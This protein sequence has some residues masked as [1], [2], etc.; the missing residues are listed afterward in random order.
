MMDQDVEMTSDE[1]FEA[2]PLAQAM[3]VTPRHTGRQE[4][5]AALCNRLSDPNGTA[6][7][8]A[9]HRA[10]LRQQKDRNAWVRNPPVNATPRSATRA[11]RVPRKPVRSNFD[12]TSASEGSLH[13]PVC[14]RGGNKAEV[15]NDSEVDFQV[16]VHGDADPQSPERS[17]TA[18]KQAVSAFWRILGLDKG[19]P[20][21]ALSANEFDVMIDR[22][23]KMEEDNNKLI[24]NNSILETQIQQIQNTSFRAISKSSWTLLDDK[25]IDTIL[26]EIHLDL[27]EWCDYNCVEDIGSLLKL[28]QEMLDDV[29]YEIRNVAYAPM[30]V[31]GQI[32]WWSTV[33]W[34][35]NDSG[36][37]HDPSRFLKAVLANTMYRHFSANPFSILDALQL[38]RHRSAERSEAKDGHRRDEEHLEEELGVERPSDGFLEVYKTLQRCMLYLPSPS[39]RL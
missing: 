1:P 35:K 14:S 19:S 17:G 13:G 15:G 6:S 8:A 25:V 23:K 27:D 21:M 26:T 22:M 3:D 5:I 18:A 12:S 11:R 29:V 32:K 28:P 2:Q 36:T 24:E 10:I 4:S 30:D 20:E 16:A 38:R 7:S 34:T 39:E 9:R 33:W 37:A 31:E